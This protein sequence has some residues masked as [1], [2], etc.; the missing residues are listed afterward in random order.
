MSPHNGMSYSDWDE[1]RPISRQLARRFLAL[2]ECQLEIR[3]NAAWDA[4]QGVVDVVGIS[5]EASLAFQAVMA[6]VKP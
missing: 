3:K 4:W 1:Y 5:E 2:P 6:G